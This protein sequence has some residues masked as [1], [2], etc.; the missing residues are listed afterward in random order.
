MDLLQIIQKIAK[1]GYLITIKTY[2]RD[3]INN[4]GWH[5]RYI[6]SIENQIDFCNKCR[7]NFGVNYKED[8]Y[9]NT[10]QHSHRNEIVNIFYKEYMDEKIMLNELNELISNLTTSLNP[11]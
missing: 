7:T 1:L 6:V 4:Y 3:A 5:V 11:Q 2:Y 9:P 10:H 8:Y